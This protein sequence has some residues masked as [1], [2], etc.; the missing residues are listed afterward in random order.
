MRMHASAAFRASA[1]GHGGCGRACAREGIGA[2]QCVGQPVPAGHAPD[3]VR[4]VGCGHPG[5]GDEHGRTEDPRRTGTAWVAVRNRALATPLTGMP[6]SACAC[7]P[8]PGRP[9]LVATR[10]SVT[11][12]WM[13]SWPPPGSSPTS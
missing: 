1:L 13:S 9:G 3:Q 4:H 8:T 7:G 11:G 5:R 2:A 10:G 12:G 6:D